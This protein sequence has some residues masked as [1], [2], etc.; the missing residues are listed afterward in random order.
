MSIF[1]FGE[2]IEGRNYKVLNERVVRGSSGVMLLIGFIAFIYGF[3]LNQYIVL[4]YLSGFLALS[5]LI[6]VFINPKFAPTVFLSWLLV[7]KQ[8]PLPIG[9][10][11]KRFAWSLGLALTTTIFIMSLFLLS[12][13]S[14]FEPVCML[15]LICL[16]FL[17]LETVFGICVGCQLYH[18]SVR[19]KVLPKP[20]E[21]P[22]CMGD[23]C[24]PEVN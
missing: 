19:L 20:K 13:A 14:W 24:P 8:S 22:I 6:A 3:I 10:I 4:P 7:R 18:L 21:K 1:S 11:Q 23:V 12:D 17:Y 16:L 2:Y 9:A 5:F 15:C